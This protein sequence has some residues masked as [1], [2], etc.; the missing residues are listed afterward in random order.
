MS[1]A[2]GMIDVRSKPCNYPT[3]GAKFLAWGKFGRMETDCPV[4]EP[5]NVWFDYGDTPEE[6]EGKV[7]AEI[8]AAP[9]GHDGRPF[10]A[11]A[12]TLPG[13]SERLHDAAA[14][15][16]GAILNAVRPAIVA[17]ILGLAE[18]FEWLTKALQR[19]N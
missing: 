4:R 14:A 10:F 5:G 8:E 13:Q 2:G 17:A 1:G 18:V 12:D 7:R 19:R 11:P 15:L 6:A 16:G 9:R 3:P